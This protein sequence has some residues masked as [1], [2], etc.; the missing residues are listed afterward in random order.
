RARAFTKNIARLRSILASCEDDVAIVRTT[1]DYKAARAAGK[2]AAWIGIQ[3]GNALDRDP[4]ALDLIPEGLVGRVTLVHLSTS[5][6]GV[7]SAPTLS[8]DENG[9]LSDLGRD[10]VRRLNAKKIFVDLAHIHRAGFFDAIEVHDKSQPLIV[11][12]TGISGVTPHWRNL[13]DDQLRAI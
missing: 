2:H 5:R 11:T 13:D 6:L 9:H 7:T 8:G 12:H 1:S 4:D 3:G 10:Y